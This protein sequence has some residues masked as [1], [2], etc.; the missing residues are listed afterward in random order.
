LI[1]II[2]TYFLLALICTLT[3]GVNSIY[4]Q[5]DPD[6]EGWSA[7][8]IDLKATKKLSFSIAEHLRLRNDITTVKN[9][10][11]QLKVDYEVLKNFELGGGVRYITKNDDVGGNQGL[12]SLF[13][14]QFDASYQ[15]KVN[16]ITVYTRF[17]YQ[18]KNRLGLSESE[19]DVHK[20]QIRFRLGVGYTIKPIKVK[21]RLSSELF[22]ETESLNSE[23]GINRYRHVLRFSK[24]VKKIGLFAL[25]YGL[26][27]DTEGNSKISRQI[28][29]FKYSYRFKI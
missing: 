14:Y 23:G 15:H 20:E 4:A 27:D 26:Q 5:N 1:K 9:Y 22:N 18:N 21:I 17:R 25:F 10:F 7:V 24:R 3:F 19:G 13:R 29:G 12:R 8:E 11:T 16:A 28:L 6:L 2:S